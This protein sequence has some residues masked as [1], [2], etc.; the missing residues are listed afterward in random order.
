MK[1]VA[2]K[3]LIA[4]LILVALIFKLTEQ[5]IFVAAE[6]NHELE[7]LTTVDADKKTS[8]VIHFIHSVQKTPV[9]E[10]L[11]FDG[12]DFI[13][14]RTRYKSH[15]V[16]LPFMESDGVFREEGGWFVMDE[17][18]RRIKNLSL[19]TGVGTQLTLELGGETFELYKKY[20]AGTKIVIDSA[21]AWKIF[22]LTVH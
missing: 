14:L 11:E 18:N 1:T 9:I 10:E 2:R 12:E 5:K 13:L 3:I 8:L 4:A 17:M 6:I 20:P 19:R 21:S 7:I 15:G 16:G 22:R